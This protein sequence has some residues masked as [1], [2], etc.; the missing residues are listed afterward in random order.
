MQPHP[1]EELIAQAL[2]LLVLTP[3]GQA[4]VVVT[5]QPTESLKDL[6]TQG[7]AL[8]AQKKHAEALPFFQRATRSFSQP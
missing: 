5:P 7:R 2:R 6:L 3:R 1:R 4:P 8:Q